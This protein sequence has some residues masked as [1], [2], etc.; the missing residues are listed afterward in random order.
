MFCRI[1]PNATNKCPA[2]YRLKSIMLIETVDST[3]GCGG[4]SLAG[5]GFAVDTSGV[6]I[7]VT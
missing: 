1:C 5:V 7:D 6:R 4:G 3:T 2:Q